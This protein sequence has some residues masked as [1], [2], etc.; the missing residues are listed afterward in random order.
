[1]DDL[2]SLSRGPMPYVTR[3][4]GHIVNGYRF[5]V[6]QYGKYLKTQNSGVVVVGETGVE[7][8]H[9]NYYGELTEV[10]ELQFVR[11][12][13]NDFIAMYVV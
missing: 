2:L 8:N 5:H 3:F 12:N 11:G 4:K 9:M 10:L 13:K 7:Q 6:K 1:M